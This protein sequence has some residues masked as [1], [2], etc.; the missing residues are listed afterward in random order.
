LGSVAIGGF[1]LPVLSAGEERPS[2]EGAERDH[3]DG[4]AGDASAAAPAGDPLE[5]QIAGAG[6]ENGTGHS[7]DQG[8]VHD[9]LPVAVSRVL[10]REFP[11]RKYLTTGGNVQGA[12]GVSW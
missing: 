4:V 8:P 11:D 6:A 3:Q 9:V 1:V 12:G 10:R 5:D 2:D 7:A